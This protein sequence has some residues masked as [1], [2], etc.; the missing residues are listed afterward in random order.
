MTRITVLLAL[1]LSMFIGCAAVDPVTY[2][3]DYNVNPDK[4]EKQYYWDSEY[5][6]RWA[7]SKALKGNSSLFESIFDMDKLEKVYCECMES[8]GWRRKII[9]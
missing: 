3:Y 4:T 7:Q 5:C 6:G 8:K 2:T 1:I 9:D